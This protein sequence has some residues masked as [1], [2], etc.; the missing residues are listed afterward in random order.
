MC[1]KYPLQQAKTT[2]NESIHLL[3]ISK[4]LFSFYFFIYLLFFY[5]LQIFTTSKQRWTFISS[6][7]WNRQKTERYPQPHTENEGHRMEFQKKQKQKNIY[8]S[9]ASTFYPD[10]IQCDSLLS[11]ITTV[12]WRQKT[13]HSSDLLVLRKILFRKMTTQQCENMKTVDSFVDKAYTQAT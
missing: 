10:T 1:K 9:G 4:G 8:K 7:A 6:H 2:L 11:Q 12:E 5:I 13:Q 3:Q